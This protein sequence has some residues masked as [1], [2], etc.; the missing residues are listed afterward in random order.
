MRSVDLI[1]VHC[2]GTPNGDSLFRGKF[3][4][5]GF[6]TPVEVI[7]REH[8]RR[9]FQRGQPW[10]NQQNPQLAAIGYHFVVYTNGA[11]A[12]GRHVDEIGAHARGY[13]AN[14]LGLSLIG[15]DKF[16]TKQWESLAALVRGLQA[17]YRG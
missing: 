6:E 15:T 11:V 9:G 13:N 17:T 2:T 10:R 12:T 7:D 3:Q 14:S 8:A 1:I 16:T 5:A 4:D